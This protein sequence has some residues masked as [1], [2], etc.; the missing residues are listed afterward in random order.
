MKGKRFHNICFT[1]RQET[2]VKFRPFF[3]LSA[4]YSAPCWYIIGLEYKSN[5]NSIHNISMLNFIF[6]MLSHGGP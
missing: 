4:D 5:I 2:F 6:I 3:V 1:E